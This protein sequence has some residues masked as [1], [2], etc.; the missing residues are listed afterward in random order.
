MSQPLTKKIS[1]L[2]I[3][4]P[5]INTFSQD[6]NLL[7]ENVLILDFDLQHQFELYNN[8]FF[9][10]LLNQVS[11]NFSEKM[12]KS[13]GLFSFY[14]GK[15]VIRLSIIILKYRSIKEIKETLLHE[16]IHAYCYYKKYDMSDDLSGHGYYFKKKMFE[17]NKLTGFKISIYHHFIKEINLYSNIWRCNGKCRNKKPNFGFIIRQNNRKPQKADGSKFRL[18]KKYCGGEYEKLKISVE[19]ME[20]IIKNLNK[21][22]NYTQNIKKIENKSQCFNNENKKNIYNNIFNNQMKIEN[23]FNIKTPNYNQENMIN[24]TQKNNS[25]KFN[26][27]KEYIINNKKNKSYKKRKKLNLKNNQSNLDNFIINNNINLIENNI[28]KFENNCEVFESQ[29][30]KISKEKKVKKI[31]KIKLEKNQTFIDNY[32][33]QIIE[34]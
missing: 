33:K 23:F 25:N 16:M 3:T 9:E 20:N 27:N 17:I 8:I 15:P 28:K 1:L 24:F 10:D 34:D 22:Y 5:I 18:H 13:A 26:I 29:K 7:K 12:T 30:I 4:Q 14:N 11:V 2:N 31:N 6:Q 19:E 21:E 32:L